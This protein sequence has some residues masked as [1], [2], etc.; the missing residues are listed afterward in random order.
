MKRKVVNALVI[1]F[2]AFLFISILVLTLLALDVF[3][4]PYLTPFAHLLKTIISPFVPLILPLY[5]GTTIKLYRHSPFPSRKQWLFQAGCIIFQQ[6]PR[7]TGDVASL[8][9]WERLWGGKV[10]G[11]EGVCGLNECM[12]SWAG[13]LVLL[14]VVIGEWRG[15]RW[16]A[17]YVQ[18]WVDALAEESI[19]KEREAKR[20]VIEEEVEAM[21]KGEEIGRAHV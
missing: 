14:V 12:G 3:T 4:I 17:G 10:E 20:E 1:A 11:M 13:A 18:K 2:Y 19:R 15:A 8:Y 7:V 16:D 21:E 5:I 9:E 6:I